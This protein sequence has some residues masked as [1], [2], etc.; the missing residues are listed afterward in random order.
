MLTFE[1]AKLQGENW[2]SGGLTSSGGPGGQ[3]PQWRDWRGG[4]VTAPFNKKGYI[5]ER[6]KE[7]L[8]IN[9]PSFP[10]LY[11]L[12]DSSDRYVHQAFSTAMLIGIGTWCLGQDIRAT[13]ISG[14]RYE[15]VPS[16]WCIQC[17]HQY[18]VHFSKKSVTC[19]PGCF[20][21]PFHF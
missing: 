4:G 14:D 6:I 9:F 3:R 8:K 21:H 7:A 11:V 18:C 20:N 19:I 10:P 1:P 13:V 5:L 2:G 12:Q 16:Y 17:T 15:R